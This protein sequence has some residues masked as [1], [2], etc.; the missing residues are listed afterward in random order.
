MRTA[1][2]EFHQR[3]YLLIPCIH[4][5][6]KKPADGY[7][8]AFRGAKSMEKAGFPQFSWGFIR[9]LLVFAYFC[10][11]SAALTLFRPVF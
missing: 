1:W 6:S 2:R 4:A 5:A 3:P 9:F 11:F 8:A 10:P 7:N